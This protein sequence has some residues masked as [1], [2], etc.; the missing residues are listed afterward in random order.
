MT[1]SS[2]LHSFAEIKLAY[3]NPYNIL[4]G[5]ERG[6]LGEIIKLPR[7]TAWCQTKLLWF[8]QV[9]CPLLTL[10]FYPVKPGW[11]CTRVHN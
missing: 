11:T 4:F 9:E 8:A 1:W 3:V 2:L 7:E 10:N 5:Q 6:N